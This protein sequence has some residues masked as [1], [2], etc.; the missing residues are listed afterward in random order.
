MTWLRT[1]R[2][3]TAAAFAGA[4]LASMLV[5]ACTAGAVLFLDERREAAGRLEAGVAS[6]AGPDDEDFGMVLKVAAAMLVAAPLTVAGAALLGLWLAGRALGPM[7]EAAR[8]AVA[9]RAGSGAL[10][11]PVRGLGDEWDALAT[12]TNELLADQ[13]RSAERASAFGANAAHE[14]RT[15]LTAMLGEVQVA[16]RRERTPEAYRE[17]LRKTEAEVLRLTRLVERLLTLARADAGN[18]RAEA[19]PF[20][21]AEA[22]RQAAQRALRAAPEHH[23]R[24]TVRATSA[25]ALGDHVLTGRVLDNLIDNALKHGRGAVEVLVEPQGRTACVAVTDHGGGL[26]RAVRA[27]LFERFNRQPGP[28]EGFGLGLAIARALTE[29]EGGRLSLSEGGDAGAC[30]VLELPAAG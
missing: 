22:A 28:V 11:L 6:P 7:R 21:L 10:E 13:R 23:G 5:F 15:P 17:V 2:A 19:T 26:P 8:R 1:V 29:A 12:V 25:M 4:V 9:A 24:L 20:D 3:R 14:L 30:F 27:R 16:L 18:L